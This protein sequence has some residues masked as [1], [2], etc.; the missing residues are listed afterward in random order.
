MMWT[1]LGLGIMVIFVAGMIL[2]AKL[3]DKSHDGSQEFR[4]NCHRGAINLAGRKNLLPGAI[5]VP[6]GPR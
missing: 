5:F 1:V 6:K 2:A 4:G 3:T